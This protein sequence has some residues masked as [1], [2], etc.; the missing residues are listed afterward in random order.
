MSAGGRF[1]HSITRNHQVWS[2]KTA[3]C[4]Y[5]LTAVSKTKHLLGDCGVKGETDICL[6]GFLFP[7]L[8]KKTKIEEG[9]MN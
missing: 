6:D 4:I 8:L 1:S 3:L 2:Q 7:A 9:G 5:L